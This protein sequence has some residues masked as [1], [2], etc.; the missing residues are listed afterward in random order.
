MT[1]L[2]CKPTYRSDISNLEKSENKMADKPKEV[3]DLAQEYVNFLND[4]KSPWHVCDL[5][6][7]YFS[8][9]GFTELKM[10]DNW[11]LSPGGKYYA[12]N[13]GSTIIAFALGGNWRPTSRIA[14]VA[15]H[16]DSPVL[17]LKPNSNRGNLQFIQVGVS[18]YGGG[19]WHTWFDR[20]L[21]LAGRVF[22]KNGQKVECRLLSINKS[23]ANVPGLAIHFDS[24]MNDNL[25]IDLEKHILPVIALGNHNEDPDASH[26]P[27]LIDYIAKEMNVQP[28]HI[29][30]FE[31][32]MFDT[33][34]A[35][36]GGL[37][38][39]FVYGQFQDN[40]FSTFAA[41][42][43]IIDAINQ[44]E[45]IGMKPKRCWCNNYASVISRSYAISA[46]VDHGVN[47]NYAE[48]Y[49]LNSRPALDGGPIIKYNNK[50]EM[51]TTAMSATI[52]REIARRAGIELQST[53]P[54]NGK[55]TG[56][57]LGPTLSAQLGIV[58]CDFGPP[59]L[60][61][62]SIRETSS[63]MG[64]WKFKMCTEHFY[65]EFSN[66]MDNFIPNERLMRGISQEK[67]N[68]KNEK[69]YMSKWAKRNAN[70]RKMLATK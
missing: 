34:P 36:I 43:A 12:I 45:F 25:I 18:L 62:H 27:A 22:I 5:V 6:K 66:V 8:D 42:K 41:M 16:T 59:I 61:M 4:C 14:V 1:R 13:G 65:R 19:F 52:I 39:D 67:P 46:D 33:K 50:L 63:V 26:Q 32:N 58:T 10:T 24:S 15:A 29:V 49:E 64:V 20:D 30:E 2:V 21:G 38:E 55:A 70:R 44:P 69:G 48:Y 60:A 40:S 3:M 68:E 17:R 35:C 47:P 54:K 7:K 11:S 31:L 53:V 9:A 23:I 28:G 51:A 37:H 56:S 57:T